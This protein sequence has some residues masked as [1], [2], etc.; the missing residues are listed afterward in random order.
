MQLTFS[1]HILVLPKCWDMGR[2]ENVNGLVW[3]NMMAI[4]YCSFE[5]YIDFDIR[6][7]LFIV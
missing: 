2:I 3:Y 5:K 1:F 7:K 4:D 6:L